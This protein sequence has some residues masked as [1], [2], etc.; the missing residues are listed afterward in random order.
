M[1]SNGDRLHDY[2]NRLYAGYRE[3]ADLPYFEITERGLLKMTVDDLGS[4]IDGH[5]HFALNETRSAGGISGDKVLYRR[6]RWF[7]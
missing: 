2:S 6:T 1:K 3:L 5:T 7:L 4:G